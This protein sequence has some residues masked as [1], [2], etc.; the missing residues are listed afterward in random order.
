MKNRYKSSGVNIEAG[1][2]SVK[3]IKGLVRETH[4]KMVPMGIG[5]FGGLYD[6]KEIIKDDI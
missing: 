2:E 6:L 1:N 4:N 5:N 3:R